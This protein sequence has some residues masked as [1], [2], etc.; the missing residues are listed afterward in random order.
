MAQQEIDATHKQLF[1]LLMQAPALI[2]LLRGPQHVYELANHLYMEQAGHRNILG[3]PIRTARPEMEGLGVFELL[4]QVYTTGQAFVGKEM[5]FEVHHSQTGQREERYYDFVYQPVRDSEGVVNGVLIHGVEVTEQ[6]HR[7]Q[8]MQESEARLQRLVHSNVIGISFTRSNGAVVDANERFLH[9]LGYT[10]DDVAAGRLNWNALTPPEYAARDREAL[11]EI[12]HGGAVSQPYEK[13]YID[14]DG[15]RIPVLVGGASLNAAQD[16]IVTFVID[17]RPQKQLES[18]LRTAKGQLEAILKNA[19]D[20]ITV[21]DVEGHMLYVNDVAARMSGFPSADAMLTASKETYYQTI[22]RFVVKDEG[23]HLLKP[24][25][26]PGRRALR[27]GRSIQQILSYYDSAEERSFW[28]Y[29]K[30]QPIFNEEGQ[31]HLVVNVLVD[32]S[33]QQALEQRKNEFISMASHELKTPVTSLKGFTNILQR[34]LTRQGD[35]QGLHYLSRMDVQLDKLTALI[36]DL[37]DISR[38]QSGKLILRVKPFDLDRLVE[39]TVENVQAATTTHRLLIEGST[40]SWVLGDQE[41][42]A[43]VCVNLLTNAIKYSPL[44]SAVRVCL[45]RDDEAQ[46]AVISVQDFGIGIDKSHHEHLFE[47]FYQVTD[48]EEKTYP[49]LGIGLYIS[50][51]IV[52]RHQGRMW[53][54]SSKG[55]GSTFYVALPL[56][57]LEEQV[58]QE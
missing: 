13:E 20:G 41:R 5:R 54:E 26:F 49:G 57:S 12:K 14:K 18:E 1:E 48:P 31:A 28:S 43:Q 16:E 7:R 17:M 37:L 42:L 44:S 29:I 19:G 56:H 58:D 21:H 51:E 32:M 8:K 55:S 27:E 53:V 50:R 9:M 25:D 11:R 2:A 15:N 45:F 24:E 38:M 35:E 4:D 34:R 47:R 40:G 39:E 30:S 10:R 46:Q 23:G 36:S 52:T 6:V 22:K 3:L 33:E